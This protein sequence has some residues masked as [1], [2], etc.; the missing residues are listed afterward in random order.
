MRGYSCYTKEVRT[1]KGSLETGRWYDV[2]IVCRGEDVDVKLD[3]QSLFG[4]VPI[5]AGDFWR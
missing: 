1:C 4:S 5:P 2:E 3:G